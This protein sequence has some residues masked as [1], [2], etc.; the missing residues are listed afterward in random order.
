[1]ADR[2]LNFSEFAGKYSQDSEIDAAA[3]YTE[4]SKSSDKFTD[5]FDET[6]YDQ[7]QLGPKRPVAGGNA[8]TPAQPGAE[9]APAFTSSPSG[10]MKFG[11]MG[12]GGGSAASSFQSFSSGGSGSSFDAG[13][14]YPDVEGTEAEEEEYE[15]GEEEEVETQ[16]SNAPTTW[17]EDG[18]NPEEE[19]GGET[20][21]EEGGE[22]EETEEEEETEEDEE[23]E[24]GKETPNESLFWKKYNAKLILESFMDE[25]EEEGWE[26]EEEGEEWN[27][28]GWEDIDYSEF[29]ANPYEEEDEIELEDYYDEE[30][31]GEEYDEELYNLIMGGEQTRPDIAPAPTET[32]SRPRPWRPVPTKRP[33][34]REKSKPI[35]GYDFDI[36]D[37][38]GYSDEIEDFV[39]CKSC[40][41][42]KKLG[43]GTSPFKD[44]WWKGH[45]MGMQCGCNM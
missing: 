1:M 42:E 20:E 34:E 13:T 37:E 39:K 14:E 19:E 12:N 11:A 31:E 8:M 9:G 23:E 6:T 16:P 29:G 26:E 7:P 43:M 3:G 33:S 45:E 4:F 22:T 27:E 28:E 25:F 32:P 41:E 38:E 35:A 40:G 5:A 36:E 2:V 15:E 10:D 30:G 24:E 44:D 18:G 21:E 17:D